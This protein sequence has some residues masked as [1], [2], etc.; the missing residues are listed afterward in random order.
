MREKPFVFL[1]TAAFIAGTAQAAS[2][3]A[4]PAP[5]GPTADKAAPLAQQYNCP[6]GVDP[7]KAPLLGENEASGSG[8]TLSEQLAES[9]GIVCPP[10]GV[11]PGIVE[12]PPAGGTL[13]VIPP[14]Q[15]NVLP[16]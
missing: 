4:P 1:I 10:R 15:G 6:P 9:G 12:P 5:A 16:K 3:Q 2:A 14:P 13:R 7:R 8:G 11:D